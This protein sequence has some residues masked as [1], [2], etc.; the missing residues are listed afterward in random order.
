MCIMI[1]VSEDI[2]VTQTNA[3]KENHAS[4]FL[5][6]CASIDPRCRINNHNSYSAFLSRK[7]GF[8]DVTFSKRL[9]QIE[10]SWV[11]SFWGKNHLNILQKRARKLNYEGLWNGHPIKRLFERF[12]IFLGFKTFHSASVKNTAGATWRIHE[13]VQIRV[14][15]ILSHS[16]DSYMQQPM[17]F[18]FFALPV[19]I[20][21][22]INHSCD[23][24][25]TYREP[26]RL[27]GQQSQ[28]GFCSDNTTSVKDSINISATA[29]E[30]SPKVKFIRMLK[31]FLATSFEARSYSLNWGTLPPC[32]SICCRH[33]S[34]SVIF[35]RL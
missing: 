6:N 8:I 22:W 13:W 16:N 18:G 12:T 7:H 1:R 29:I 20:P 21:C 35:L 15:F 9:S 19:F 17:W 14:V 25:C 4:D 31:L 10:K 30:L 32:F 33:I 3:D 2:A 11:S 28:R 27:P 24:S 23:V 34:F 5:W 26:F